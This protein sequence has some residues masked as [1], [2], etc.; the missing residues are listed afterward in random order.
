VQLVEPM[1]RILFVNE[2]ADLAYVCTLLL[3]SRGHEVEAVTGAEQALAS[4]ETFAPELLV[5]DSE[6]GGRTNGDEL[7]AQLRSL[8]GRAWPIVLLAAEDE[9]ADA[10]R[11]VGV[12]GFV[13]KPFACDTLLRAI[14]RLLGAAERRPSGP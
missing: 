14:D 9:V 13:A 1:A 4:V 3:E 12:D 5:L 2:D 8:Y 11:S 7:A 10:R 6:I